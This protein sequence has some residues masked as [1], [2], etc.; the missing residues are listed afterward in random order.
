M[1]IEEVSAE[2]T[3]DLRARVLRGGAGDAEVRFS[4]DD[5]PATIHLAV[6]DEHRRTVA[7]ASL[8]PAPTP[9]RPGRAAWRLRGMAVEPALQGG[10]IGSQLLD[11]VVERGRAAG[12]DV[13]WAHGRDSALPFYRRRGWSVE[14]DGYLEV[15]LPH[16]TVVLDL[17]TG[18]QV[19]DMDEASGTT[20]S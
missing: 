9:L 13:L 3:Y 17:R 7:V 18:P 10:G 12:A 2:A 20:R 4:C 15:G 1:Q 11:A 19:E 5:D 6:S 14:G 8:V 16:H